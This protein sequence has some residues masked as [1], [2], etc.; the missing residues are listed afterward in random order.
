MFLETG[1]GISRKRIVKRLS[2]IFTSGS[3]EFLVDLDK[4]LSSY[5]FRQGKIYNYSNSSRL[6]YGTKD[7]I[8][9]FSFMYKDARNLFLKRKVDKFVEYF[10]L[11][12]VNLDEIAR[13][14]FSKNGHV[15]N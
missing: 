13:K 7:S 10:K 1:V 2:I 4:I 9:L 14:I 15:A 11:R 12:P 6:R 3:H 5:G 8:R